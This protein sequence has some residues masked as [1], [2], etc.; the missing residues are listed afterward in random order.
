M[1]SSSVF[2]IAQV[3]TGPHPYG[4]MQSCEQYSAPGKATGFAQAM[5][6]HKDNGVLDCGYGGA[7]GAG[8]D[9]CGA[10]GWI[11]LNPLNPVL[12]GEQG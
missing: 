11:A 12:M 1:K 5:F 9:A 10:T 6:E 2:S 8:K 4:G 7:D 3:R